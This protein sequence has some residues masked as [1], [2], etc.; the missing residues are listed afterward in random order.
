MP[1][2]DIPTSEILLA[3]ALNS[4]RTTYFP[5]YVG[6]RLIGSQMPIANSGYLEKMIVRRLRAGEMWSYRP[7]KLYKG[8]V[9]QNGEQSHIYRDCLASSPTTAIAESIILA[10]LANDPAFAIPTR[11]FS[12]RWPK[13]PYSGVSYEYFVSGYNQRNIEI[14]EALVTGKV[15][16]VTDI[17]GFYP[18]VSEDQI[19]AALKGRLNSDNSRLHDSSE[20]IIDFY[21]CLIKAGGKGIP[22]GPASSHVLGHLVLENVDKELTSRYGKNYFRYVDDIVVVVDQADRDNA[23]K[24]IET[25]LKRYGFECN[26]DKTVVLEIQSW[27]DRVLRSD[28]IGPDTFR[29]FTNDLTAYLAFHPNHAEEIKA[30]FASNGLSIP[31]GRL[32]A[33]SK[34]SRYRY[35]LRKRKSKQG[36]S[37]ALS[38]WLSNIK[39]FVDRALKLKANYEQT[40]TSLLMEPRETSVSLRRWQVQRVRRIINTM[41]YLRAF[42]EWGAKYDEMREFPELIEQH[43]L[44]HALNVGSVNSILPFYG[45]GASAFAE[46]WGEY[47]NGVASFDWPN[48]GLNSAE[49]ESMVTL[50]LHGTLDPIE[51]KL[52]GNQTHARLMGIASNDYP[53]KRTIPDLSFEDELESLR[54]DIGNK[55][56]SSLLKTRYSL[57]EGTALDAL[58]LMSSEYRS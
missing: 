14:S 2:D 20:Q 55:D 18:S 23:E 25:T 54:L 10:M 22:I 21:G 27:N 32:L 47:G 5:S 8:T 46:L 52:Y 9:S 24:D 17:K 31:V 33:I 39:D 35:F 58:S 44:A 38:I 45:R 3:R 57:T 53:K 6:L 1:K 36:L 40:L 41:F 50:Q 7:F 19:N 51:Q 48:D 42:E 16:V 37:H 15:A 56:L 26:A 29:A 4:T 43:A 34:Y 13:S 28:I 49:I 11:A 30:A 12:Y